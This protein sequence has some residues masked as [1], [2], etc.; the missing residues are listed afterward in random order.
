MITSEIRASERRT[1]EANE[2][3]MA[4]ALEE[5]RAQL[6]DAVMAQIK[7]ELDTFG[8]SISSEIDEKIQDMFPLQDNAKED[9]VKEIKVTAQFLI[10]NAADDDALIAPAAMIYSNVEETLM[11]KFHLPHENKKFIIDYHEYLLIVDKAKIGDRYL[12]KIRRPDGTYDIFQPRPVSR[13]RNGSPIMVEMVP[14]VRFI[15]AGLPPVEAKKASDIWTVLN[16]IRH[17]SVENETALRDFF[18]ALGRTR[19]EF[20]T[21][22]LDFY[23][24]NGLYTKD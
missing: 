2:A 13:D 5:N 19:K 7:G 16:R 12:L 4:D 3:R 8:K 24:E 11:K 15:K 22:A 20:L 23:R 9:A 17:K 1:K 10:D 14:I 6:L 18:E 21:G